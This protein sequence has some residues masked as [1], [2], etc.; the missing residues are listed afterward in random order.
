MS[1]RREAGELDV[2]LEIDQALQ[3]D[4]QDL[5]VPAGLLGQPVVGKDVG[6]LLGLG[7]VRKPDGRN[8]GKPEQLGRLDPPVPGNDLAGVV[9]QHRV[10]EAEAA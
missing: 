10:G 3:L 4:R 6:P 5:A 7:E 2:E 8:G 9:D 1:G